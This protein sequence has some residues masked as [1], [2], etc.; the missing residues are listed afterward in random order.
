[1]QPD[2]IHLRF[3]ILL[4]ILNRLD[5]PHPPEVP[6]HLGTE[7]S[8]TR[9]DLPTADWLGHETELFRIAT[10]AIADLEQHLR[11]T[12][13]RALREQSWWSWGQGN[14]A[15]LREAYRT[16]EQAMA[17]AK[18]SLCPGSPYRVGRVH[19]GGRMG[20][21]AMDCACEGHRAGIPWRA[22]ELDQFT[23]L[24]SLIEGLMGAFM[25]DEAILPAFVELAD[26]EECQA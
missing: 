20:R 10:A 18:R 11:A 22:M 19:A 3:R 26:R 1:M 6:G 4:H 9:H 8:V 21:R 25:E 2:S 23:R 13:S 12:T 7:T 5:S 15:H 24:Q 16:R 17:A 14:S